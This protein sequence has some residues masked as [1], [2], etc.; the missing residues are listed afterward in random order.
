[1][2]NDL[3]YQNGYS[4]IIRIRGVTCYHYTKSVY[5]LWK[6]QLKKNVQDLMFF[7]FL[8]GEIILRCFHKHKLGNAYSNS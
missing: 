2:N 6:I 1:M 4:T 7:W 5:K 8:T 3:S